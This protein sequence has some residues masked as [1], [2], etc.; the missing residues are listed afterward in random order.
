MNFHPG[1]GYDNIIPTEFGKGILFLHVNG[2]IVR[3]FISKNKTA[4]CISILKI[5]FFKIAAGCPS[6]EFHIS[7]TSVA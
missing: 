7:R 2:Q 4:L 5:H 3:E 6:S 1:F